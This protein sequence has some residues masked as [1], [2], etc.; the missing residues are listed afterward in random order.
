LNFF[1]NILDPF[2]LWQFWTHNTKAMAKD[3]KVNIAVTHMGKL[4]PLVLVELNNR[5]GTELN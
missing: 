5:E 1:G 3:K 4:Q 2:E